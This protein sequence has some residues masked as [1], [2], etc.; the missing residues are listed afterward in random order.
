VMERQNC[1][2]SDG[3]D[4]Q[5]PFKV[6]AQT[7]IALEFRSQSSRRVQATAD[8]VPK[9]SRFAIARSRS[10]GQRSFAG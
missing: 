10:N 4:Q 7:R 9:M 8:S 2:Q 3:N 1:V 6:Q 5:R